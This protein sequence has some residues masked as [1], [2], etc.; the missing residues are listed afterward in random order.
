MDE[1]SGKKTPKETWKRHNLFDRGFFYDDEISTN[2]LPDHVEALRESILYFACDDFGQ[3]VS[4]QDEEFASQGV[5]LTNRNVAEGEWRDFFRDNFFE[6]LK[7][8]ILASDSSCEYQIVSDS[9]TQWVT[10]NVKENRLG[11]TMTDPLKN[12][13]APKPDYA[14]YFPINRPPTN[15]SVSEGAHHTALQPHQDLFSLSLL[16]DLCVHGL[17]P[18]P[19]YPF[20]KDFDETDLKCFPWLVIEFKSRRGANSVIRQKREEVYCQAVNGS[21]C[22]VRLNEIAALHETKLPGQVH[23]PPIPAVTT[24]GP[25]VKVWITYLTENALAYRCDTGKEKQTTHKGYM[26]QCIWNGDMRNSYDTAKF[27]LI[28]ENIYAWATAKFKPLLAEYLEQWRWI[29]SGTFLKA[30]RA[31]VAFRKEEIESRSRQ[32]SPEA[33]ETPTK[34]LNRTINAMISLNLNEAVTPNSN[35]DKS[36]ASACSTPQSGL[37]RSARIKAMHDAQLSPGATPQLE[38][39]ASRLK[40]TIAAGPV[41][42]RESGTKFLAAPIEVEVDGSTSDEEYEENEECDESGEEDEECEDEECEDD[43]EDD[44]EES[45]G[46]NLVWDYVRKNFKEGGL[47][48]T[49]ESGRAAGRPGLELLGSSLEALVVCG[50]AWDRDDLDNKGFFFDDSIRTTIPWAPVPPHVEALRQSM[51]DFTC[52]DFDVTSEEDAATQHYAEK[53]SEGGYSESDWEHFFRNHFF[54]PLV[55]NASKSLVKA[56]SGLPEDSR[57]SYRKYGKDKSGRD[58]HEKIISD[59]DALW[60]TFNGKGDEVDDSTAHR[61]ESVKCPKPDYAFYLPMYHLNNNS[62]IPGIANHKDREWHKTPTPSIMESFSWSNLKMLYKDGLRPTP[63]RV[64]HKEPREKDLKCYPWLLVE[65]KKE[66]YTNHERLQLEETVCCQAANGSASAIKL[67]QIAARYAIELPDGSHIPPIPLVTTVGSK[68]KVWITYLAKDCMVL[69]GGR[70]SYSSRWEKRSQAYMMNCIWKGDM[71]VPQ[72][73][74]KFR[75][76]LENTYTWATRVFKPLITTYIDQWRFVHSRGGLDSTSATLALARRQQTMELSGSVLPLIQ[77]VLDRQSNLELD[78][79]LHHRLTPMLMGVLVQQIFATER[80]TLTREMD[81]IVAEKVKSLS[82]NAGTCSCPCTSNA[83]TAATREQTQESSQATTV[84]VEDPTDDDYVDSQSHRSGSN[85]STAS[86]PTGKFRRST[87]LN[88]QVPFPPSGQTPRTPDA[89]SSAGK[90][91]LFSSLPKAPE[92]QSSYSRPVVESESYND[93]G[94]GTTFGDGDTNTVDGEV[95]PLPSPSATSST[96]FTPTEDESAPSPAPSLSPKGP[97]L[98]L[99][100]AGPSPSPVPSIFSFRSVPPMLKRYPVMSS[101]K[102]CHYAKDHADASPKTSINGLMREGHAD[103]ATELDVHRTDKF[104]SSFFLDSEI[105]Q[106]IS[107]NVLTAH[108][109]P[110]FLSQQ[111][112]FATAGTF[113]SLIQHYENSIHHWLSMLSVK[114]LRQDSQALEYSNQGIVDVLVFLALEALVTQSDGHAISPQSNPSYLKANH[115]SFI[116]ESGGAI[117]IRLIQ[118]LTLVALYELGHHIYPAAYLT[119]GQAVRLATMVG[120]HSQKDAQQLFVEPETWTL[121]EE[122]RRTWW[123]IVMLD[124]VVVAGSPR[125]SMA[126]PSLGQFARVCQAVHM[127]GKVLRHIKARE[128]DIEPVELTAEA[129]QLHIVLTALDQGI[130]SNE[131][132]ITATH[133]SLHSALSLCSLARLLL[134]NEYACNEPSFSTAHE[135][136]AAEVEM[137]QI[138]LASIQHIVSKTIPQMARQVVSAS[139]QQSKGPKHSPILASCLYHAA[140]ECAWFVKENNDAEMVAGLEAITQALHVLKSEWAVCGKPDS[141]C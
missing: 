34:Q 53:Y 126:A 83:R 80:Q 13:S 94:R 110:F 68:V 130:A 85:D 117:N 71:T 102:A 45:D 18:S 140:T 32:Q 101:G 69:C 56:D 44:E 14:F 90:I 19:Y 116:A 134:Y 55:K 51:L 107:R 61:F 47:L 17:R 99:S 48:K 26:M 6:P 129:L 46:E 1:T 29:N 114:R 31:A 96:I 124:R 112:R 132:D 11:S 10:F 139:Q 93:P 123:V 141:P 97:A 62:R 5:D 21:G 122:Q 23:I 106:P 104:P 75:L 89:G 12:K 64:F 77:G 82:M 59:T 67:N 24:V 120:L 15:S 4:I 131:C 65:Y 98:G 86:T 135:R 38:R 30:K 138:A 92:S 60:E 76:I 81:R 54:D 49:L 43:D 127:F 103:L 22:A 73:I 121:C 63:F 72:D 108:D 125:L 27:R 66:K 25:E 35:R 137:Q 3:K 2:G 8:R 28:L 79:S 74:V 37:R 105:F 50:M 109:G 133:G 39:S 42:R 95:T 9:N 52:Q 119:I 7:K 136:L 128:K 113:D 84:N 100:L 36:P 115:G 57:R 87:R 40:A 111:R 88:P 16:K 78:D 118:T 33:E 70:F 58:A 41:K 20:Q 91:P